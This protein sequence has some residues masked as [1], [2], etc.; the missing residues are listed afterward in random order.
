MVRCER[1]ESCPLSQ[2]KRGCFR[3]TH[4]LYFPRFLYTTELEKEFRELP[5]NK[6]ELCRRE[7]NEIHATTEP[8]EKPS[9]QQM[10]AAVAI[11]RVNV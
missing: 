8:P 11:R 1:D 7:H 2:T 3:D 10:L 9:R 4:H 6:V 5:E